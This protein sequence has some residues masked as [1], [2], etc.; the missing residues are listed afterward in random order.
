[1]DRVEC[2]IAGG[3]AIGLAVGR[4]LALRG[5]GVLVIERNGDFGLETSSR[6]SEVIHAGI[7]YRPGSLKARLCRE[8]RQMLVDYLA[9]KTVPHSICGKLI[10]AT[11]KEQMA[12]VADIEANAR[13]NGVTSLQRVNRERAFELEPELACSGGLFSPE[14]GIFDS[15]AYMLALLA[16][17]EV[18][19]GSIAFHTS[20]VSVR[21]EQGGYVVETSDARGERYALG[22]TAFVNAAGL[23]ASELGKHIE[24]QTSWTAPDTRYA[25]GTYYRVEGKP[26]FSRLV[27]PMPEPG[28]LGVHLTLDLEGA[29][30]FGPDVE[31]IDTVDYDLHDRRREHFRAAIARYWPGIVERELFPA[32]C[33][34]R[35]KIVRQG[36]PDGDFMIVGPE[37]HGMKHLVQLFG[38][39]SPGLTSSLAI[40][41]HVAA[42][43]GLD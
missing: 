16:D 38:I 26:V 25:R 36:E 27:Y 33:G 13:A 15:R 14:T 4:A 21:A 10:V 42:L 23:W 2:I 32:Y 7:Y 43:V 8:G 22:C 18:A 31:W 1:M 5:H 19:G 9:R 17:I 24:V 11:S 6:N 29:M 37:T 20:V 39:E 40:A 35:P 41:E 3:G 12:G 34:V 28:G 30:R